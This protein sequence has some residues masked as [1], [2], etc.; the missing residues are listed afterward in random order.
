MRFRG[1]NLSPQRQHAAQPN[2]R[3]DDDALRVPPEPFSTATP[4]YTCATSADPHFGH[5]DV[6]ISAQEQNRLKCSPHSLHRISYMAILSIYPPTG[7][8]R[9]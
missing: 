9:F 7:W 2:L 3:E 5:L 4:E 6:F 8:T 1:N